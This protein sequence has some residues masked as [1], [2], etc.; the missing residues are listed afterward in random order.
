MPRH[1]NNKKLSRVDLA[2]S[3]AY[4]YKD[5]ELVDTFVLPEPNEFGYVKMSYKKIRDALNQRFKSGWSAGSC[6][7]LTAVEMDKKRKK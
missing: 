6:Y 5:E 4:Q 3:K 2:L 7:M 1:T